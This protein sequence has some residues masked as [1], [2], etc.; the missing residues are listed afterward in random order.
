MLQARGAEFVSQ[1]RLSKLKAIVIP[2]SEIDD[3]LVADPIRIVGFDWANGTLTLILNQAINDNW[4]SALHNM[5]NYTSVHSK[6]PEYFSFSGNK[7]TIS[8][9]EHMVQDI[10]N[11]FKS[12]MPA[13]TRTYEQMLIE[14]R[15]RE[16][17]RKRQQLRKQIEEEEAKAR[18]RRTVTI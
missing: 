10:I 6:G 2:A 8:A 15:N 1:Q 5:G 13:T 9:S 12:W 14:E 16:E 4:I 7:A 11:Y 3:P 17:E 18:I